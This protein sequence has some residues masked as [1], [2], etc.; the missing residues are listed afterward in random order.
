MLQV[1]RLS[2]ILLHDSAESVSSFL[3]SQQLPNGAFIGRANTSDLYYTLFGIESCLALKTPLTDPCPFL[4]T[5]DHVS[6]TDL[7]DI[8]SLARCYS[9]LNVS[10]PDNARDILLGNIEQLKDRSTDLMLSR[11]SHSSNIYSLFL[12]L[13]FYQDMAM[14]ERIDVDKWIMLLETFK[15]PRGG[16]SNVKGLKNGTGPATAAAIILQLELGASIDTQS[17]EWLK[18]LFYPR[19]GFF[20]SESTPV[21]DLLTTAVS[22]HALASAQCDLSEYV[23]PCLNYLDTLWSSQGSFY[24]NWTETQLDTEYTWYALLALGHLYA[25]GN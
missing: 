18:R 8:A 19:G 1:A 25:A 15:T 16:Y 10:I 11:N 3:H 17:V 9:A 13:G 23:E 5:I 7:V 4:N 12:T 21:P 22:L 6:L 2:P 24:G 20:A 14:H